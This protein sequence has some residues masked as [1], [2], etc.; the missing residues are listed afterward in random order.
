MADKHVQFDPPNNPT[1]LSTKL[2]LQLGVEN[3]FMCSGIYF[4]NKK[5]NNPNEARAP[6][7]I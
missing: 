5:S 7:K 6:K 2:D 3:V 4:K 1:Q